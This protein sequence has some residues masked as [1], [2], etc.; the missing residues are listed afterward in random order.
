[1]KKIL[2]LLPT[3]VLL[4]CSCKKEGFFNGC[5]QLYYFLTSDIPDGIP[6]PEE[7]TVSCN[8]Q[9][10]VLK[11]KGIVGSTPLPSRFTTQTSLY[12]PETHKYGESNSKYEG[13]YEEIGQFYKIYSESE[14][15]EPKIVVDIDAND[16]DSIRTFSLAAFG[17]DLEYEIAAGYI[18]ITQEAA[19]SHTQP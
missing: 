4:I 7:M 19:S 14:N 2:I 8:E 11:V 3:L 15:G 16:T 13:K 1:M 9:T 17:A 12:Y 10:V 6:R 5:P 18:F